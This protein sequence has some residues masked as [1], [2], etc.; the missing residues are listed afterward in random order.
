MV[1]TRITETHVIQEGTLEDMIRAGE[2]TD[3]SGVMNDAEM[4]D[5]HSRK[6]RGSGG[7]W[8]GTSTWQEAVDLARSGWQEGVK[9]LSDLRDALMDDV[10]TLIPEPVPIMDVAGEVVDVGAFVTGQPEHMVTWFDDDGRTRQIHVVVNITA[11]ANKSKESMMMRGL[12]AAGLVDSLEHAGHRVRLDVVSSHGGSRKYGM[13]AHLKRES[14]VLDLERVVFACA[15][16]SMLRRIVFGV[17]ESV[18]NK[19]ARDDIGVG[20]TYGYPSDEYKH[21]F[22][23]GKPDIY[24]GNAQNASNMDEVKDQVVEYLRESGILNGR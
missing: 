18:P 12:L 16:P 23:D 15:H 8:A 9:R 17:M 6:V 3:T 14:E 22:P 10:G 20:F 2:S 7:G 5:R 13:I 11:S 19:R 21:L 1:D 24:I 4:E